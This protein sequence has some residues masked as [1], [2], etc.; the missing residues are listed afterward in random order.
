M[1]KHFEDNLIKVRLIS[2]FVFW[3]SIP[4]MMNTIILARYEYG[5]VRNFLFFFGLITFLV[6]WMVPAFFLVVKK[7]DFAIAWSI[8]L[9]NWEKF[10]GHDFKTLSFADKL[11]MIMNFV[12]ACIGLAIFIYVLHFAFTGGNPR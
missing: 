10:K 9:S 2:R 5:D 6:Y 11:L 8:G 1:K 3:G 12:L 4:L 7:Q